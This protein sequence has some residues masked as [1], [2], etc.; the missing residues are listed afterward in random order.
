MRNRDGASD[1]RDAPE[2]LRGQSHRL[3]AEPEKEESDPRS[4]P[5]FDRASGPFGA[6]IKIGGGERSIQLAEGRTG[7]VRWS[8]GK[9]SGLGIRRGHAIPFPPA[10][11]VVAA[12]LAARSQ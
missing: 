5:R 7:A 12:A 2:E 9:G 1:R 10:P 3:I 4:A 6:G 8:G 11:P